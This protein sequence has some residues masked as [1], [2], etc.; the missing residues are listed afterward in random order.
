MSE[1]KFT[2]I[3][4]HPGIGNMSSGY[5]LGSD[6]RIYY[7]CSPTWHVWATRY[8]TVEELQE[9]MRFT[10]LKDGENPNG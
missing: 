10:P 7:G 5:F 3:G 9:H 1:V 2:K 8:S 4:Y 6:G